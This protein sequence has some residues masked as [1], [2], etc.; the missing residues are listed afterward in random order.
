M[1]A[2]RKN[3][4]KKR[5]N[6]LHWWGPSQSLGGL[7][8]CVPVHALGL[9]YRLHP[10]ASGQRRIAVAPTK[11]KWKKS[12]F[13]MKKSIQL[14]NF[15]F[16]WSIWTKKEE[17]NW[18]NVLCGASVPWRCR[19][20]RNRRSNVGRTSESPVENQWLIDVHLLD[21]KKLENHKNLSKILS[22]KFSRLNYLIRIR[23]GFQQ[24]FHLPWKERFLLGLD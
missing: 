11:K 3:V 12:F 6:Y 20:C 10:S 23:S 8:R 4:E 9:F 21:K 22:N 7:L 19:V 1:E 5:T 14:I 18:W 16:G 24:K 15:Y 17:K 2:E 13:Y